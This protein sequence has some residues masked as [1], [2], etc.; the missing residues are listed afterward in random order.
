M[1]TYYFTV[2]CAGRAEYVAIHMPSEKYRTLTGF[3]D[4]ESD[5]R[6]LFT[7]PDKITGSLVRKPSGCDWEDNFHGLNWVSVGWKK[8]K[9]AD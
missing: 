1:A 8:N 9:K 3:M 6:R 5:A 4:S 7:V 2:D